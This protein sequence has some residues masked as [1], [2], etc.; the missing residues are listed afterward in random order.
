MP[1]IAQVPPQATHA[2][3]SCCVIQDAGHAGRGNCGKY[4]MPTAIPAEAGSWTAC[5]SA[6]VTACHLVPAPVGSIIE[7]DLSSM[8]N[9]SSWSGAGITSRVQVP[10]PPPLPR[11]PEPLPM[12]PEPPLPMPLPGSGWRGSSVIGSQPLVVIIKSAPAAVI[13]GFIR[14]TSMMGSSN[15][16]LATRPHGSSEQ[17][18]A[19]GAPEHAG[20][21][22][23]L[24]PRRLASENLDL[25]LP[26]H[27]KVPRRAG[28][29]PCRRGCRLEG[30]YRPGRAPHD[31]L[32]PS[33]SCAQ[34]SH[35]HR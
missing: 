19:A 18:E 14:L 3:E 22:R 5:A 30:R 29:R 15:E 23:E 6:V 7:P 20:S 26:T 28:C 17:T 31:R 9:M 16:V 32:S 12:P 21:E 11:P 35:W 2:S 10:P 34:H 33:T 8:M 25:V 13:H 24:Q 27:L 1:S 4:W